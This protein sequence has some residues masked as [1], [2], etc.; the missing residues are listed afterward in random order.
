MF[1]NTAAPAG[2]NLYACTAANTW[3][4]EGFSS[5]NCAYNPTSQTLQCQALNGDV[6]SAVLT[7]SSGTPNQWIDYI[8]P[9]GVPHTSQPTAAA[10]GAVGDPGANGVPYRS[11][12][13]AATAATADNLSGPFFCQDSG[14][15]GA[16]ACNLSPA[17]TAYKTGTTYW[18]KANTANSG[19]ATINL[20]GIGPKQIVKAGG[21]A[22]ASSDIRAG[23]WVLVTYD[24]ANMQMQSQTAQSPLSS[25]FGRTGAVAA[26]AGDYT[27][28]QVT[29]SGNLYFTNARAQAAFSFPGAVT[30]NSGAVNC[31][32]CITTTTAADT[33][34]SGT[35]PHLSVNKIQGRAVAATPQADLQYLGWNNT[36]GWWEPKTLSGSG[37]G[38]EIPS[39][40]GRTGEILAGCIE[41]YHAGP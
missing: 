27:T 3:S 13:G 32:T 37:P 4:L 16:Y 35:F 2:S 10:V 29:E 30:L 20:N 26:Q 28:A 33:D 23:Q 18:F 24:G 1:F 22:L 15:S 39:V 31:P 9:T 36:A 11:G 19:A 17:I 34:L 21:Q 25:V 6:F 12:P 7:S 38:P 14:T 40:F 8:S 5:Q 41:R